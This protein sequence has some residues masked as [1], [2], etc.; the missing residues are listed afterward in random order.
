MLLRWSR[1]R[2]RYGA[3]MEP[4]MHMPRGTAR[5]GP[6]PTRYHT[7][8]HNALGSNRYGV[9][10]WSQADCVENCVRN[11]QNQ[12]VS[13]ARMSLTVTILL[14]ILSSCPKAILV[15]L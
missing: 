5:P 15:S 14:T 9:C 10:A 7:Y 13:S 11:R 4:N 2:W 3:Y 12:N 1:V 8:T 6:H